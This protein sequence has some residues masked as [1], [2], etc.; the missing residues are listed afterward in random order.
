MNSWTL[1]SKIMKLNE[2]HA[3][4]IQLKSNRILSASLV[5]KCEIWSSKVIISE[6]GVVSWI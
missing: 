1:E 6:F 4:V 5:L 3:R 2:N